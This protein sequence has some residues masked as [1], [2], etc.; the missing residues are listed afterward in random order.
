M[1]R[2]L[3][4]ATSGSNNC[5]LGHQKQQY[6]Q[7][8][9]IYSALVKHFLYICN[10]RNLFGTKSDHRLNQL[11]KKP[12][13]NSCSLSEVPPSRAVQSKTTRT[14]LGLREFKTGRWGRYHPRES[15]SL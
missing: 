6:F 13:L 8:L 11:F 12:D 7:F 5:R 10:H 15:N 9:G 1:D 14:L 4:H 2:H 3:I